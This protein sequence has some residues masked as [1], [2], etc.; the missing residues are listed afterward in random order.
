MWLVV[1]LP[2]GQSGLFF[3][4]ASHRV[5]LDKG[6]RFDC[7]KWASQ[8]ISTQVFTF[9]G[10]KHLGQPTLRS[11]CGPE[12]VR[13]RSWRWSRA[14]W[15]SVRRRFFFVLAKGTP[16]KGRHAFGTGSSLLYG[17]PVRPLLGRVG[18][19]IVGRRIG[20]VRTREPFSK[21][22]WMS[23]EHC[24]SPTQCAACT[25]RLRNRSIQ[26]YFREKPSMIAR[27]CKCRDARL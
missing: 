9:W 11:K 22:M 3:V 6:A 5:K 20:R 2:T 1:S 15:S 4:V 7:P 14:K 24:L 25:A 23:R 12:L 21:N 10:S 26:S 18:I 19:S 17:I 8:G 16:S 27:A 13:A